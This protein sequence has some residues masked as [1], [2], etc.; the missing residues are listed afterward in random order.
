MIDYIFVCGCGHTGSTI[1]TRILGEN[2]KIY[3]PAYESNVF[4]A[5]NN[6]EQSRELMKELEALAV[7]ND[8]TALLEKTVRHIWHVDY[9]RRVVLNSKFLVTTRNGRD[10]IGSL[11]QR[12]QNL[13]AA[14]TRYRDDSM[15]TLRQL[16]C[17]DTMLVRYEDVIQDH[18]KEIKKIVEFTGYSWEDSMLDYHKK[19]PRKWFGVKENTKGSGAEG[20]QHDLLRNW[21]VNQPIFD[22]R[23]SWKKRIPEAEWNKLDAFFET[24]GNEIMTGLGY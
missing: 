6:L 1:L 2:S 11:Y 9:I 13:D 20:E 5:Y 12:H 8:C 10:V 17:P 16:A 18:E 24:A 15:L 7:E 3:A 21:Q 14:I 19:E 22:G 23:N 4:L